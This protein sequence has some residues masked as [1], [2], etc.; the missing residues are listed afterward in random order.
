MTFCQ[1]WRLCTVEGFA[2][3]HRGRREAREIHLAEAPQC[4]GEEGE[5]EPFEGVG[6]EKIIEAE[7]TRNRQ[8]ARM[9]STPAEVRRGCGVFRCGAE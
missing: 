3:S 7:A 2:E 1:S 6:S 4:V 9:W 5:S 8:E